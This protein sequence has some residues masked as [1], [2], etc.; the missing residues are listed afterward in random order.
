MKNHHHINPLALFPIITIATLLQ[1]CA[2]SA[3]KTI[4]NSSY[5]E[6]LSIYRKEYKEDD[7]TLDKGTKETPI[8]EVRITAPAPSHDIRVELDSITNIIVDTRKDVNYV[9]G[10][11]IQIYSGNSRDQA[12]GYK[13]R[14]YDLLENQRPRV[15][16][17]QPNYKV[18]VGEYYSKLEANKDY[19]TLK[20]TFSRAVL[21]PA[22]IQIDN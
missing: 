22:K 18:K 17:D 20:K 2:P 7:I 4:S 10:F 8:E 5:S 13:S 3:S 15:I 21:I 16:Y 11:S 14:A 9:D 19:N 1:F 12:N 6:D